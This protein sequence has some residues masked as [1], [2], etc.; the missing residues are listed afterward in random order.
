MSGPRPSTFSP[1]GDPP[2]MRWYIL[3][4]RWKKEAD[5]HFANR[6]ALAL[7]ALLVVMSML[8][9]LFGD[10][11]G[12]TPGGTGLVSG[13]HHVVFELDFAEADRGWWEHLRDNVPEE[14]KAKV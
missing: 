1:L 14:V 6:G 11:G 9:S 12:A 5:R 3:R 10:R 13:M 4:T 7:A 8:L 2:P